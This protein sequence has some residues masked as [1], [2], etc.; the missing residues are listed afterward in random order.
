MFGV[1][2]EKLIDPEMRE[3]VTQGVIK[4]LSHGYLLVSFIYLF[5]FFSHLI[6]FFF[7]SFKIA[8]A[9]KKPSN[10]YNLSVKTH[11]ED[12]INIVLGKK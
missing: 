2:L 9:I 5:S 3:E 1:E 4:N 11:T 6:F 10:G 8:N 7:L 12:E